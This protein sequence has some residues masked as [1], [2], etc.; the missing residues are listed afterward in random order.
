MSVSGDYEY[1]DEELDRIDAAYDFD[2]EMIIQ[3]ALIARVDGLDKSPLR[4]GVLDEFVEMVKRGYAE[5]D[6]AECLR[7]MLAEG[8]IQSWDSDGGQ[9]QITL[10]GCRVFFG[11]DRTPL[12]VA[13][14]VAYWQRTRL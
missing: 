13:A 3:E 4:Y 1:S 11:P 2:F 6:A 14:V 12:L 7:F 9:L 10:P 8:A 5:D